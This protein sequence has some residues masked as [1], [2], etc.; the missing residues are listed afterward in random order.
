MENLESLV[1]QLAETYRGQYGVDVAAAETAEAAARQIAP[2][3]R[4]LDRVLI[5]RSATANE[6]RGELARQGIDVGD[7]YDDEFER[8][9]TGAEYYWEVAVPEPEVAWRSFGNRKP[10]PVA[11]PSGEAAIIGIN[12]ISAE[13][14]TVYM[15]EHLNNISRLLEDASKVVM[16]I[17]LDKI[18]PT[19]EEARFVAQAMGLFGAPAIAMTTSQR[20]HEHAGER[21]AGT[22]IAPLSQPTASQEW[23]VI[24]LDNHR[25][26]L[27][28]SSYGELFSCIGCRACVRE[29]PTFPYLVD[30]P[31][32]PRDHLWMALRGGGNYLKD[33]VSCGRCAELCPMDIDLPLLICRL[34]GKERSL[35]DQFFKRIDVLFRLSSAAAPAANRALRT[36]LVRYPAQWVSG[37]DR[38]RVLPKFDRQS[39]DHRPSSNG[40]RSPGRHRVAYFYG[41]YVNYTDPALGEAAVSVLER[42]NCEVAIPQQVCC[43]VAAFWYGDWALAR[44]YA[45]NTIDALLPWVDKGYRV[46]VTCPSCGLALTQDFQRLFPDDEGVRRLAGHTL[47]V[48][49]FLLD[50][51]AQGEW[52]L[53]AGEVP[54]QV[55]YHTPC[56]LR[57]RGK[58]EDTLALLSNV[59]GL[60]VVPV[61]R[62][63]CGLAGSYGIK[64]RNYARSI[65]IGSRVAGFFEERS[66]EAG[67]TDCAGCEMQ[68]NLVTG[69]SVY[70]PLDLIWRSYEGGR[71]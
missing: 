15:V 10:A 63:C 5:N 27:L 61:D 48:P 64:A 57:I 51:M 52:V 50:L 22:S 14:G 34:K 69:L 43:G 7:S 31:G 28:E 30:E 62:G 24:L 4:P 41:C 68:L 65:A 11:R 29:C 42:N 37:L 13:D 25:R 16:I 56:H 9:E 8:P 70:H 21:E 46:L 59:P 26:A 38:R 44:R 19:A 58:G 23:H 32:T 66:L 67:C 1:E 2:I 35:R 47:D 6:I 71:A 60:Q 20:G 55:G 17:G 45:R 53:P 3:I 36:P 54:L 33:C 40:H 18:A 49:T 39:F 12:S